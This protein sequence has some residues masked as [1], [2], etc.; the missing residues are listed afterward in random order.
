MTG[1]GSTLYGTRGVLGY[2]ADRNLLFNSVRAVNPSVAATDD[3]WLKDFD[4]VRRSTGQDAHSVYADPQFRS[5]PIAFDAL[6]SKRLHESS[7]ERWYMRRGGETFDTGDLV[8]VN[9]DG[10]PRRVTAVGDG[11]ITVAPPLRAKPV[12]TWLV[13]N[14]GD[15]PE[16]AGVALDL[17]LSADSPGAALSAGGGPVGSQI[18]IPAFQRGDFTGDGGRDLPQLGPDL[19]EAID[20]YRLW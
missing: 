6:D 4:A 2:R 17:R 16:T 9:F 5:A 8:E 15:R 7:R 1:H 11:A 3:G 14:W 20:G 18:D 10:V 19:I 12:Q 13:A